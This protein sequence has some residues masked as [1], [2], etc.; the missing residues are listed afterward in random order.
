VIAAL[1]YLLDALLVLLLVVLLAPINIDFRGGYAQELKLKGRIGWAGGLLS[2][3]VMRGQGKTSLI[4][5]LFGLRKPVST[6]KGTDKAKKKPKSQKQRSKSTTRLSTFI[7]RELLAAVKAA[8][9]KLQRAMHLDLNVSGRYGFDDPSLTGFAMA[10]MSAVLWS[11]STLN[12]YPDFTG[13]AL[14]IQGKAS[15]YFIPLQIIIIV[16]LFLLARPVRAIW[17]PMIK[18]RKKQKEAVQYA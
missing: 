9:L 8:L 17:W 3:E 10:I 14:D 11:S 18:M 7:N 4:L 16:L 15:G 2:L 13:E 12:F 6:D 5:G 1:W